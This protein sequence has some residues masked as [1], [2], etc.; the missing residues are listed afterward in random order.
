LT[1]P[2]SRVH[3]CLAG[4]PPRSFMPPFDAILFDLDGTLADSTDDIRTALVHAFAAIGREMGPRLEVLIDGSPLEEIYAAAIPGGTTAE[5]DRFITAYR[6]RYAVGE[7]ASTR[8][9]PG[10]RETLDALALLRPGLRLAVATSKREAIARD[11]LHDLG[12]AM[13][14][15]V[16][17]GSGARPM[18]PKP[19]PDLL[20]DVASQ[21]AVAP[22]RMLMVGD[23]LR[24]VVAGQRAGMRTAAVTYGLGK[25]EALLGARP[26]FVLEDFD[27]LLVIVGHRE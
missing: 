10:V 11:V 25:P 26:D 1:L 2:P 12:V 23:T 27:E 5:L 9:Y 14:F 4:P 7:H 20:L 3:R 15:D 21:L 6:A 13:H 24:D 17:A 18:P 19:A 8:L 22:A 16:I